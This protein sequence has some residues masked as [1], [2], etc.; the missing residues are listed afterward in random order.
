[1]NKIV[2]LVFA[3]TLAAT[4]AGPGDAAASPSVGIVLDNGK[5]I[6]FVRGSGA[7]DTP[8]VAPPGERRAI[9]ENFANLYPRGKYNAFTGA[10]LSGPHTL[11]GQIWLAASFTPARNA[12]LKEVEVAAE[13]IGGTRNVV[14]VGLY[15]DA[16]GVPGTEIWSRKTALP[17]FPSCCGVVALTDKTGVPVTAGTRYWLGIT[18]LQGASDTSAAWNLVVRN[19]VKGGLAAQNRGGGWQAGPSTPFFAFGIYGK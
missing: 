4:M 1:M 7:A 18:T 13:Y 14:S 6:D 15:E 12:T 19:Q 2:T 8:A 9:Y 16:A 3:G 5:P 11:H 17:I 10:S